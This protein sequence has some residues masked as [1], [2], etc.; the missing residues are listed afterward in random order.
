MSRPNQSVKLVWT[1]IIGYLDKV[2]NVII[3]LFFTLNH[4]KSILL[5]LHNWRDIK[6]LKEAYHKIFN[7][8]LFIL[9]AIKEY[10]SQKQRLNTVLLNF[11]IIVMDIIDYTKCRRTRVIRE[12]LIVQDQKYHLDHHDVVVAG[13]LFGQA[14]FY[15]VHIT[16]LLMV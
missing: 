15:C 11:Q 10:A 6:L 12:P 13:Y 1:H 8:I 4:L 16:S 14:F 2:C 3:N 9:I 5:Q 7:L